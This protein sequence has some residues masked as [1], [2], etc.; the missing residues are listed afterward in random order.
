MYPGDT[1]KPTPVSATFSKM[2][3]ELFDEMNAARADP[4]TA[5]SPTLGRGV[6]DGWGTQ[7]PLSYS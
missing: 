1:V 7:D 3:V 5:Y 4:S 2:S 6:L